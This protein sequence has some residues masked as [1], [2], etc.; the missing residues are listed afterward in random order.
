MPE[1]KSCPLIGF[2][3]PAKELETDSIGTLTDSSPIV[4]FVSPP[5]VQSPEWRHHFW[6]AE[7]LSVIGLRADNMAVAWNPLEVH[8]H[9]FDICYPARS[10]GY[11]AFAVL[12]RP[13]K[14]FEYANAFH[15]LRFPYS[16]PNLA[17]F[18]TLSSALSN[19]DV[20]PMECVQWCDY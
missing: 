5:D 17:L 16:G 3:R 13:L 4:S 1:I 12:N 8:S 15:C 19:L 18:L 14:K 2:G 9:L 11:C 6:W 20:G 7:D 10:S